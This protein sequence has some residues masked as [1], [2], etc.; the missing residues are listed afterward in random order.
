MEVETRM[1]KAR[2]PIVQHLY[3]SPALPS[4][5]SVVPHFRSTV[6]QQKGD[7]SQK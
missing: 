4:P 7:T 2:L 3:I 5:E 1:G 6:F